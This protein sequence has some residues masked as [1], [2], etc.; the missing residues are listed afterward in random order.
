MS[1][2][3]LG[4]NESY[5]INNYGEFPCSGSVI[6]TWDKDFDEFHEYQFHVDESTVVRIHTCNSDEDT[7]LSLM[8]GDLNQAKGIDCGP[9]CAQWDAVTWEVSDDPGVGNMTLV[10]MVGSAFFS[11]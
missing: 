3:N 2:A 1:F 4:Y 11:T 9:G 8:S 10:H 6:K 7:I 5:T